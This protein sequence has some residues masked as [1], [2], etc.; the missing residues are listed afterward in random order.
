MDAGNEPLFDSMKNLVI[1]FEFAVFSLALKRSLGL[2]KKKKAVL[3]VFTVKSGMI[4]FFFFHFISNSSEYIANSCTIM[5]VFI[6]LYMLNIEQRFYLSI[7]PLQTYRT[8][9]IFALVANTNMFSIFL[10]K[11]RIFFFFERVN[12]ISGFGTKSLA[13]SG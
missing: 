10:E 4:F 5:R 9:H 6:E 13:R 1:V 11:I 7:E 3:P 8:V 2:K 12:K